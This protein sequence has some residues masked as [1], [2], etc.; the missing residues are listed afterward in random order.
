MPYYTA[1]QLQALSVHFIIGSGRSG[2]TLLSTVFN[3]HPQVLATPEVRLCMVFYGKYAHQKPVSQRFGTDLA[4]YIHLVIGRKKA[5]R[6]AHIWSTDLDNSIFTNL[7]PQR[8]QD[9][10]YAQ[11]YKLLQMNIA[12]PEKDNSTVHT[13]IDKNPDYTFYVPQLLR[14]FPD[15]KFVVALRD[16]RS[17]VSSYK[18]HEG[19]RIESC[20][21]NAF[22]WNKFNSQ[23]ARLQRQYPQ[24]LHIV[25]YEDL[26]QDTAAVV[27]GV[28]QFLGLSFVEQM[29][30]PHQQLQQQAQNIQ[31]NTVTDRDKK[32]I[33]EL[34]QPINTSHLDAW[35]KRLT[36]QE[37]AVTEWLCADTGKLFGY[38]PTLTLSFGKKISLL[39]HNLPRLILANVT[40]Q[41]LVKN[42]FFLPLQ[43]RMWLIQYLRITR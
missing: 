3:A 31:Q 11:L 39:L 40:F 35:R 9:L 23:I 13:I 12:L 4:R 36:D 18:Y 38:E 15:A 8:V 14:L 43:I 21:L 7:D 26:V 28:C 30:S 27:S 41:L 32:K 25:R 10:N 17:V 22:M 20:V 24:Q 19:K 16:Y 34:T 6:K 5:T 37:V 29:L 2:T 33:G 1:E 42:Y